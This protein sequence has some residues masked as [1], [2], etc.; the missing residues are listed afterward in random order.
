MAG[1]LKREV[2][3]AGKAVGFG[4]VITVL[5]FTAEANIAQSTSNSIF[6][7]RDSHGNGPGGSL[8]QAAT[9]PASYDD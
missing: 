8:L 5:P 9:L 1:G 2:K 4:M 6:L 3:S 7:K